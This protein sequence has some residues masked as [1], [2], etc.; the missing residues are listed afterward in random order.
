MPAPKND[1]T[2]LRLQFC[3]DFR[4]EELDHFVHGIHAQA[5]HARRDI[6]RRER[7]IEES[8]DESLDKEF[9]LDQLSDDFEFMDQAELLGHELSIVALYKKVEISTK[10]AVKISFPKIDIRALHKIKEMKATLKKVGVNIEGFYAY[11]FMDETRCIN[12]DI[13]HSGRVGKEL[14]KYPGWKLND[15]LMNLDKAYQRLAPGCEQYV[16]DFVGALIALKKQA[17]NA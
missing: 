14:S 8:E 9:L 4:L 13:K 16:S 1:M 10:K 15:P 11:E 7:E 5:S 3:R 17:V 2:I 6:E 12:N